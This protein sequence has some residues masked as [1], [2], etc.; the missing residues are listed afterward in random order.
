MCELKTDDD[1]VLGYGIAWRADDNMR[2]T[3]GNERPAKMS[4]TLREAFKVSENQHVRLVK[5]ALQRSHANKVVLQDVTPREYA[6][7]HDD[8][9]NGAWRKRADHAL[10]TLSN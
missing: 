8:V 10:G 4:E 3:K 5:S 2:T 1:A 9:E 6:R 7:A